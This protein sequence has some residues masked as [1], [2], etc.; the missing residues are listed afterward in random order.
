MTLLAQALDDRTKAMSIYNYVNFVQWP[1]SAFE[2]KQSTLRVCIFENTTL[3]EE[4]K[5]FDKVALK[6]RNLEVIIENEAS[7]INSN[8]HISYADINS[9][10]LEVYRS[11]VSVTKLENSLDA[12]F[13]KCNDQGDK[14]QK[15]SEVK[16]FLSH[17]VIGGEI[18]KQ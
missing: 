4:L 16:L 12:L 8:C 5:F 3:Y 9:K 13:L 18:S 7:D 14:C 2:N 10:Q 6:D 1:E 11:E 15:Q 17:L